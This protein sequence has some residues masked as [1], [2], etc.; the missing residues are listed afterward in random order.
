MNKDIR[1][2]EARFL[3]MGNGLTL[4]VILTK[5]VEELV[6]I[7]PPIGDPVEPGALKQIEIARIAVGNN[8]ESVVANGGINVNG[9]HR[10]MLILPSTDI[11]HHETRNAKITNWKIITSA[12]FDIAPNLELCANG[13]DNVAN[14]ALLADMIKEGTDI[15]D[16]KLLAEAKE[17][18]SKMTL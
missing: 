11:Y 17:T 3:S 7:E 13:I 1:D 4:H 18:M 12:Y 8:I 5:E 10:E 16:I 14:L 2:A 6:V 9:I 15:E